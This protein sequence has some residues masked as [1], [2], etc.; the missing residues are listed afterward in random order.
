M[1]NLNRNHYYGQDRFVC[2]ELKGRTGRMLKFTISRLL[3]QMGLVFKQKYG[4]V[5]TIF[6]AVL[7]SILPLTYT[8]NIV[9]VEQSPSL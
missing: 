7:Y 8:Y 1:K 6:N 4:W 3:F 2:L 5:A 9:I